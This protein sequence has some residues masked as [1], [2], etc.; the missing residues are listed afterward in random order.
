MKVLLEDFD[1][2]HI[3]LLYEMADKLKFKVS[4]IRSTLTQIT[5]DLAVAS[6]EKE[7]T[8]LAMQ[9]SEQTMAKVWDKDDDDY[10]NS[11]L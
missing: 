9:A 6:E 8:L 11:Y 3:R 2:K 5:D 10:W 4:K 1:E 7:M